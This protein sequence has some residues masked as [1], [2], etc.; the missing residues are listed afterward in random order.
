MAKAFFAEQRVLHAD[1]F[2]AFLVDGGRVEIVDLLIFVGSHRMRHRTRVFGELL[3][4]Q[5]LD[6]GD[7]FDCA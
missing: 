6:R 4:A 3:A 2:G 7:S 1:D 5:I